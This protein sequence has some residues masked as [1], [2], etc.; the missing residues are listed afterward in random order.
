VKKK[1][2]RGEG[3]VHN[4]F[5]GSGFLYTLHTRKKGGQ[6]GVMFHGQDTTHNVFGQ[7]E[8]GVPNAKL[9]R[10]TKRVPTTMKTVPTT[11]KTVP[12]T[13]KRVPTTMKTAPTTTKRGPTTTRAE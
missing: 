3:D 8:K 2:E 13:M 1:K 5:E 12:T 9:P 4:G 11:M 10:T 7:E 6:E